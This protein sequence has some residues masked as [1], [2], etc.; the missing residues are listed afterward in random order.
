MTTDITKA[1]HYGAVI[2]KKS[3]TSF[4]YSFFFLPR[5]KRQALFSVYAFCRLI[6]DIVDEVGDPAEKAAQLQAWR[7]EIR[8]CYRGRPSHPLTR[9]IDQIL[10]RFPIPQKYF[11]ELISGVE[12][13]LEKTR[14]ATFDELYQ[15]C[16]RVASVVGLICI[17]IFGYTNRQT[18]H[19]AVN[20]GVAL[21]LTNILRDVRTDAERGR[22]YLPQNELARFH[23]SEAELLQGVVNEAFQHLMRFQSLRAWDYFHKAWALLP[24]EDR[25]S[26]CVAEIMGNVYAKLLRRIEERHYNVFAERISLSPGLKL[27]IALQTWLRQQIGSMLRYV[28]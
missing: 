3:K 12:M 9:E 14:Y 10:H 18:Q 5:T 4:Y 11:E 19:Y 24:P 2:A 17:E 15:Y 28:W 6:D 25:P 26:V 16:Y 8:N 20:L 13:D 23:Y 21:Q 27:S 7:E 22:I 1:P